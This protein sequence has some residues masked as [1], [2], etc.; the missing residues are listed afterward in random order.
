[1]GISGKIG[2]HCLDLL[3]YISRS[4][5]ASQINPQTMQPQEICWPD[6]WSRR[7]W[8]AAS[9]GRRLRDGHCLGQI[10]SQVRELCLLWGKLLI[11]HLD[12]STFH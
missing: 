5:P 7:L 8:M 12:M 6:D 4:A 10:N 2:W 11:G 9:G 1:M 3:S